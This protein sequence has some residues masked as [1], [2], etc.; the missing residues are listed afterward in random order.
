MISILIF[1]GEVW[2][3]TRA[4][5]PCAPYYYL[6][7]ELELELEHDIILLWSGFPITPFGSVFQLQL[8]QSVLEVVKTV[9]SPDIH[10]HTINESESESE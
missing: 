7:L 9:M 8:G 6:D 4:I 3:D 2:L 10:M 5:P 1:G